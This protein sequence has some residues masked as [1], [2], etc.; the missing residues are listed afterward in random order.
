[1]K[2]RNIKSYI[3]LVTAV[4]LILSIATACSPKNHDT[5]PITRTEFVLGT[6][7]TVKIYDRST[8]KVLDKVFDRLKQIE[9]RMTINKANSE[10]DAVADAAGKKPVKVSD[11][12]FFV[13]EKGID[14]AKQSGGIFDIT[15]GPLVKLWGIG[16]DHARLPL[17]QEINEKKALINYKDIEMNDKNKTIML[18]KPGMIIDLGG[19]AKGYSADEAVKILKENGVK[20]A[21]VNLG[22]N[23]FVMNS[24]INGQAWKVG[25]QNPYEPRGKSIGIV[26]VV[27]KT[28]VTSGIY[29]RY[30]EKDGKKYHHILNTQ[31][32]YPMDNSLASVTVIRD[33]SIDADAMTKA[34]FYKDVKEGLK[35][36][37]TL[38]DVEAIFITKDKKVY[39]T[40][41][42]K[43]NFKITDNEYKLM[44]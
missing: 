36:V 41:G 2:K 3:V 37:E 9:D 44:N 19:I 15:V 8:E 18:K 31:T 38:K 20:H 39:I 10:L 43:N 14:Y 33:V 34:V 28:V 11:D 13:V 42:L 12:T 35:S 1:M 27:N 16:T 7:C 25:I 6:M 40:P 29:E 32:G 22:G 21:I 23:V 5:Q 17:P 4:I 24:N 30:F 26:S